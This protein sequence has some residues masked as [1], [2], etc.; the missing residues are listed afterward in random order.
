MSSKTTKTSRKPKRSL[1]CDCEKPVL[2]PHIVDHGP[3]QP[4]TYSA[5]CWKCKRMNNEYVCHFSSIP[6]GSDEDVVPEAR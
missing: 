6:L 3:G 1:S 5:Y 4:T 2:T